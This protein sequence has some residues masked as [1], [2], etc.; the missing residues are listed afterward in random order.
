MIRVDTLERKIRKIEGFKVKLLWHDG[1]D[2][3]GDNVGA[4]SFRYI[5][6]TLFLFLS[7]PEHLNS[8]SLFIYI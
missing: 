6:T 2:I 1:A 5:K 4:K 8:I 7:L 3:G